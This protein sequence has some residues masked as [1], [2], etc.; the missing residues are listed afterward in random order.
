MYV[1]I[2]SIY[3]YI[4]INIQT[5]SGIVGQTGQGHMKVFVVG[6]IYAY[7]CIYICVYMYRRCSYRCINIYIY[8]YVYIDIHYTYI[9][10]CLYRG[11]PPG[12]NTPA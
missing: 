3:T 11:G 2:H 8:M 12:R 5:R 10:M 9:Y 1:C 4:Y 6:K 7:T